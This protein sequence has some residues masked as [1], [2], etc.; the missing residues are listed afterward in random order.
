MKLTRLT[1]E[2]IGSIL[3]GLG[4]CLDYENEQDK[5]LIKYNR[6]I[7]KLIAKINKQFF[8]QQLTK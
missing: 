2:D 5:D 1:Q 8:I 7:E 4:I 3:T 6:K